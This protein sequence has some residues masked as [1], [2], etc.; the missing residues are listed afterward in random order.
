MK[1]K[2]FIK[3]LNLRKTWPFILCE[4]LILTIICVIL[5]SLD[6]AYLHYEELKDVSDV[7]TFNMFGIEFN[8]WHVCLFTGFAITILLIYDFFKCLL[9]FFYELIVKNMKKGE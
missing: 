9:N 2:N 3:R 5:G 6:Y 4:V 1:G 8:S 7:L